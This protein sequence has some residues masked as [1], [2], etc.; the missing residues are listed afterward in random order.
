MTAFNSQSKV[1]RICSRKFRVEWNVWILRCTDNYHANCSI[2]TLVTRYSAFYN[3]D[4]YIRHLQ[5]VDKRW[6]PYIDSIGFRIVFRVSLFLIKKAVVGASWNNQVFLGSRYHTVNNLSDL[7]A[8]CKPSQQ[9][10]N[11]GCIS[12][13]CPAKTVLYTAC[14]SSG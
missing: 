8:V 7:V 13:V 10:R 12:S 11:E 2:V 9:Y 5:P 1:Y 4:G 14:T 6:R 3:N